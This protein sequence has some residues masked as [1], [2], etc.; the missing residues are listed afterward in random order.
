MTKK[1]ITYGVTSQKGYEIKSSDGWT[2]RDKEVFLRFCKLLTWDSAHSE[3]SSKCCIAL[4]PLPEGNGVI[5]AVI[6]QADNDE[7]HRRTF[8]IQGRYVANQK[9]SIIQ[10]W[11]QVAESYHL[12]LPSLEALDA[13]V[14]E[15]L[16]FDEFD[17]LSVIPPAKKWR[18][19]TEKNSMS[20]QPPPV[21]KV[22]SS[23]STERG[24]STK[25]VEQKKYRNN[26]K[27]MILVVVILVGAVVWES[28]RVE[29]MKSELVAQKD[30]DQEMRN[31]DLNDDSRKKKER[32]INKL[33]LKVEKLN[34]RIKQWEDWYES[35]PNM[36]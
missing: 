28:F 25:I 32:E 29:R 35:A 23:R 27:S 24:K 30:R 7:Y 31:D 18:W 33:K 22:K 21:T 34:G 5:V 17:L 26:R 4:V 9:E 6:F 19:S 2:D 13:P 1:I 10:Q 3:H 20:S 15:I 11:N 12:K 16:V 8:E 36:K 14:T